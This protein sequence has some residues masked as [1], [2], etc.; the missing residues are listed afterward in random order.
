MV[1]CPLIPL[2]VFTTSWSSFWDETWLAPTTR[3]VTG[4]VAGLK[5]PLMAHVSLLN[6]T[7]ADLKINAIASIFVS[8]L[9]QNVKLIVDRQFTTHTQLCNQRLNS[10]NSFASLMSPR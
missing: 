9:S 10:Y 2:E 3:Q 4:T 8:V 5:L 1:V 6:F 7:F